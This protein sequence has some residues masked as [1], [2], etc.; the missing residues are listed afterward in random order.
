MYTKQLLRCFEISIHGGKHIYC[1]HQIIV[2]QSHSGKGHLL[3]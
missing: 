1:K 3:Q 2:N